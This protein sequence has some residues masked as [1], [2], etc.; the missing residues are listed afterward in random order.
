MLLGHRW[1]PHPRCLLVQ[2]T[3]LALSCR[4]CKVSDMA[5]IIKAWAI[6]LG[7]PPTGFEY[8]RII[9]RVAVAIRSRVSKPLDIIGSTPTL[10]QEHTRCNGIFRSSYHNLGVGIR[11]R[12]R[13]DP[14][15]GSKD[16]V[17]VNGS[18]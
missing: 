14:G 17:R 1:S 11:V 8:A 9:I 13:G 7:K 2:D 10:L 15:S 6:D 4:P 18:A 5:S 12:S 3:L 16:G